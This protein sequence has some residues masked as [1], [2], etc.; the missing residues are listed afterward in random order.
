MA[1]KKLLK[2]KAKPIKLGVIMDP[3]TTIKIHHDSTFAMLLAAQARYWPLY[4]M[5]QKDLLVR[6]GVVSA[7]M[8]ELQVQDN[9]QHGFTFGKEIVQPLSALNAI[10]MRKDPPVDQEYLY[11]TQLLDLAEK[12]GVLVVNKPQSLRDFNEKLFIN[13]FPQCCA[14]TLITHQAEQVRAFLKEQGDIICKPMHGMGGMSIFRLR[15]GDPNI[16]VVVET[17]T[18]YGNNYMLVQKYIPEIKNG[19]KRILLIDGQ[20][21]PY[22]YARFASADETRAN[23]AAGG[24]GKSVALTERDRW[25]CKQLAPVLRAKGILFAGIDVI[26]DYLT[27]IN[28][29]SPTCIREL[30]REYNLDIADQLMDCIASYC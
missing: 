1:N 25:I 20:P 12:A 16:N 2:T 22:A 30:E 5:E 10:L 6:D 13:W 14:P 24:S 15:K 18:Q 9:P 19:D 26:G 21:V 3:I 8:R 11:T 28:I 7:R 4:Y 23:I 17:L 27:E 29:T